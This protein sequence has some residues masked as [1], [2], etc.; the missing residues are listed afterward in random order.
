M[1]KSLTEVGLDNLVSRVIA[2]SDNVDLELTLDVNTEIYPLEIAEKFSLLLSTSLTDVTVDPTKKETWKNAT[3][4][5]LA[6]D[7][8]YVMYGKVYKYDDS[9]SSKV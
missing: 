7:Y 3:G 4:K 9:G 1:E 5:S 8:E 2:T 6:D